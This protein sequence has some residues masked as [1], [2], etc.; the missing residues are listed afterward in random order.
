M[1]KSKRP[2]AADLE[3]QAELLKNKLESN[4]KDEFFDFLLKCRSAARLA[5]AQEKLDE[6]A[7]AIAEHLYK[8]AETEG[9][10]REDRADDPSTE[11]VLNTGEKSSDTS[12]SG[13]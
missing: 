9:E 2:T 5:A 4:I 12:V 11:T 7:K 6:N 1:Q 3:E 10:V 13:S 8:A